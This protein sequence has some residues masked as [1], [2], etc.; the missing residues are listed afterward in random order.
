M[1]RRQRGV[2]VG[3]VAADER[4]HALP[5]DHRGVDET[6]VPD[7]PRRRDRNH[8]DQQR[9]AGEDGDDVAPLR[10]AIAMAQPEPDEE[11]D[12]AGQMRGVVVVVD[13]AD[14]GSEGAANRKS[15]RRRARV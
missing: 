8:L 15:A 7:E 1:D 13:R 10:V 12:H 6:G 14:E 11:H 2:L 4:I 3:E 5:V 9:D